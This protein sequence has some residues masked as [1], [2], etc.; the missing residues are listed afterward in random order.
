LLQEIAMRKLWS[1]LVILLTTNCWAGV[2]VLKDGT[3]IEGD[4]KRT[5]DGW[6]ITQADGTTR[7]VP[8][9]KVK[10]I[11]LGSAP[12]SADHSAAGLASLRRSV[13][14]LTD[15]N[16]IIERYE[17][18]IENTK[19]E[20]IKSDARDDLEQWMDR[21]SRG[22]VKHGSKWISP[23]EVEEIALKATEVALEARELIRQNRN[24]EADTLLQQALAADPMNSAA[25]YLRGVALYRID[26]IADARKAFEAVNS[27]VP[28]HPPTLNNLAVI[29]YKQNARPAALNWYDQAMQASGVNKFILDNVAE[30]LGSMPPEQIKG[31][32]AKCQ[33]R[34]IELDVVLQRQLESQGLYRW[35][36]GWVN[37]QQLDQLRAA[38]RDI[39]DKLASLQQEFDQTKARIAQIDEM[40]AQN[41][42]SMDDIAARSWYRDKDGNLHQL[43]LPQ[44]YYDLQ[45]DNARLKSEQ[46]SLRMRLTSMQEQAK[47]VQQQVPVPKFTGVQQ[48]VGV[49]G[50]PGSPGMP[51]GSPPPTTSPGEL[52]ESIGAPQ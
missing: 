2:V 24:R 8:A 47:R 38:E 39:R 30:A 20:K 37:Q 18:F 13:E 50:M 5:S 14:A 4:V 52:T 23:D 48:I 43:Q 28:N 12:R 29:L 34:F 16:Q 19:D 44:M 9:D 41:K 26:K 46:D 31:A 33:A 10:S 21:R 11:E 27:V 15:I 3:R 17:R 40:V 1:I 25:Q 6:T 32:V 51:V 42:R 45:A 49:E 36:G 22:L 7:T 35:G